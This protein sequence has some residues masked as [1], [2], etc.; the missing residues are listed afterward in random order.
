MRRQRR[1]LRGHEWSSHESNVPILYANDLSPKRSGQ[2]CAYK[3]GTSE[4]GR[5]FPAPPHPRQKTRPAE[6]DQRA[7]CSQGL[8]Q[9]GPRAPMAPNSFRKRLGCGKR[10]PPTLLQEGLVLVGPCGNK[11]QQFSHFSIESLDKK[12]AGPCGPCYLSKDYSS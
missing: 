4:A 9:T 12:G 2:S 8:V 11:A 7:S 10:N 5:T 3:M 6:W 1:I